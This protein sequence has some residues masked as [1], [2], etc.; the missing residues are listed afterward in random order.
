MSVLFLLPVAVALIG[1]YMLIKLRA[2]FIF[3]PRAVVSVL[4]GSL[5][6][7]GAVRSLCLALAGTLGVGNIIGVAVGLIVGGEGSVFWLL[8]SSI[9][10]TVLKYS[11][12]CISSDISSG[13]GGGMLRPLRTCFARFGN[14]LSKVYAYLVLALAFLMGGSL[15]SVGAVGALS[16]STGISEVKLSVLFAAFSSVV[17]LF[18]KRFVKSLTLFVIPLITAVYI[19]FS[20]SVIVLNIHKLPDIICDI[21]KS[22]FDSSS[23]AGGVLGFIASDSLREGFSRGLL[24]NEAGAGTSSLAHSEIN[25][26]PPGAGVLGM[27]EVFFDTVVLCPL[28]ALSILSVIPD[29]KKYSSGAELVIDAFRLSLGDFFACV[30]AFCILLFAFSTVICWF[31]YG[32]VCAEYVR[33]PIG[34]YTAAFML[35]LIF[36]AELG[37]GFVVSLCDFI[38]LFLTLLSGAVIIKSSDRIKRLSELSG[39]L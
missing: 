2:F 38:L 25:T 28:T 29:V 1:G 13:G 15:Q 18:A 14:T 20:I 6:T 12:A 10:A 33:L 17:L 16:V 30:V 19:S 7:K 22:A 37:E 8:I 39:L 36:G 11:E 27:C 9:F 3:H 32:R 21:L 5:V 34:F 35:F 26:T 31:Y 4:K 24:S 23:F